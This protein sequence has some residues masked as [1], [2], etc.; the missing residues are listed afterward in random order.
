MNGPGTRTIMLIVLISY[1]MNCFG[2][3]HVVVKLPPPTHH[4]TGRGLVQA[5]L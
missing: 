2:P 1:L 4:P 3:M 5:S